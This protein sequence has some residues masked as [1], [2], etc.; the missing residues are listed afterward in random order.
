MV[1]L[2]VSGLLM[3]LVGGNEPVSVELVMVVIKELSMRE[4]IA[5]W[6]HAQSRAPLVALPPGITSRVVHGSPIPA[7]EKG[8][9]RTPAAS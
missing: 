1:Q 9:I 3:R 6:G 2:R 7:P 5:R 4:K 8:E